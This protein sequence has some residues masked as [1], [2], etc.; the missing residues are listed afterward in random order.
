[1]AK[2]KAATLQHVNPASLV[3]VKQ[4]RT[5]R[6]ENA[7]KELVSS[8]KKNGVLMPVRCRLV[9]GKLTVVDGHR[10]VEAAIAAGLDSVPAYVAEVADSEVLA[11]QM[12]ANI[13]RDDLTLN[14][15]ARGVKELHNGPGGGLASYTAERLGKSASWVSKMLL[16]A[17]G[18]DVPA[19]SGTIARKLVAT[20]KIGDLETAYL[21]CKLEELNPVAAQEV[22][23]NIANETRA[24]IK[25]KL[26]TTKRGKAPSKETEEE[27]E[28]LGP[29]WRWIKKTIKA[30]SVAARDLPLQEQALAM[31]DEQ[32]K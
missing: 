20:D 23:D 19:A 30:A 28:D 12:I 5:E 22:A 4:V 13:Q 3:R 7:D 8:V 17:G 29:M 9:N 1:M 32:L 6:N 16:V 11:Q 2:A 26:Q 14:D 31:I 10:R 18:P 25:K 27:T 15:I 24:S 21:M